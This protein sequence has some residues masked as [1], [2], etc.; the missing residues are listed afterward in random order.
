MAEIYLGWA[1]HSIGKCLVLHEGHVPGNESHQSINDEL[2]GD[3]RIVKGVTP[4]FWRFTIEINDPQIP[5]YL[6]LSDLFNLWMQ[7]NELAFV[8]A[9]GSSYTVI[10]EN[11]FDFHWISKST[12][13]GALSISL[14]EKLS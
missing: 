9:S 8:D 13:Y 12:R 3:M 4:R 2:T 11:D 5:G 7:N 14:L 6:N 10:W 1:A